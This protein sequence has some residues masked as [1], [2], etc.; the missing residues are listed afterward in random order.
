M[1]YTSDKP[2]DKGYRLGRFFQA[3][4][5]FYYQ[6]ILYPA[7]TASTKLIRAMTPNT[8][9]FN[10]EDISICL[11]LETSGKLSESLENLGIYNIYINVPEAFNALKYLKF[12]DNC[13]GNDKKYK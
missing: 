11:S 10:H 2:I 1:F 9:L 12:K 8:N 4:F 7:D 5:E 3:F 13:K 6:H